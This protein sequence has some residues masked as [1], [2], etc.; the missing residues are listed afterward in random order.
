MRGKML[1]KQQHSSSPRRNFSIVLILFIMAAVLA[2]ATMASYMIITSRIIESSMYTMEELARHDKQAILASLNHRWSA[3]DGIAFDLRQ[4]KFETTKELQTRLSLD[5]HMT[6]CILLTL[7][8][9]NGD[10]ISSNMNISSNEALLKT[11]RKANDRFLYH[12][13]YTDTFIEGR[14]E[15]LVLGISMEP[16]SVEG[17]TFAYL[18]C[19]L[20]IDAIQDEL[21]IMSYD[22]RGYSS[23]IDMDGNYVVHM[24]N[25]YTA[26]G[27]ENF[28]EDLE[29]STLEKGYTVGQIR[30]RI[31]SRMTFSIRCVNPSGDSRIFSFSPLADTNWCF[32][33][34]V[35]RTVFEEQSMS[36]ISVVVWMLLLILAV[37]I[38]AV[39]I[40]L[41]RRSKTLDREI[42]YREE[43]SH[44]LTLAEQ[45]NRAKTIFLSNMSHDMRTPMN[46]II[47]FST[48]ATTHINN[49]SRVKNY[50]GKISQASAHLLSLINDVLDMSRIESGV[51]K[52]NTKVENLPEILRN[53]YNII[54]ADVQAKQLDLHI[55]AV[56]VINED[57]ICDRLRLNQ[58]LLNLMS[59]A[60]KYT[61]AGGS[62]FLRVVETKPPQP[63]FTCFEFR[64]KD[65][66]IGMS[67]EYLKIIFDPFTRE[68][69]STVSGIQG[70]GLGMSITKSI[71]ELMN[72]SIKV[73]STQGKGSEFVVSLTFK[74]QADT[75]AKIGVIDQLSGTRAL[76]VNDDIDSCQGLARML[77]LMGM[78]SEWVSNSNQALQRTH[79][80]AEIDD[81]YKVY[82]LDWQQPG[83]SSLEAV[84]QLR[85]AVGGDAHIIILSAQDWSDIEEQARA[86]GVTDFVSKPLFASELYRV[87]LNACETISGESAAQEPEEETDIFTGKR[88]L[89]AEDNELNREIAIEILS[90][91]GFEVET[92]ENGQ[93]A[94]DML[95][96]AQPGY[97]DLILMD[98]QMPVMNGHEA[99]RAIRALDNESLA[100]IPIIAMTAN[101]FEEDKRA[102]LAAGMDGHLGKPVDVPALMD[103]LSAMLL[104]SEEKEA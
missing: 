56:N 64:V 40:I 72:G 47:G 20:D 58:I 48:L 91:V 25:S 93:I 53:L 8:A 3:L 94:V 29:A 28:F 37:I 96:A 9:D 54:Q 5:R 31:R 59:N 80:A 76:V 90:E 32:I 15:V 6:E 12:E 43:L 24:G 45:A 82:I 97:Y 77:K 51:I 60:I 81:R 63:G 17:R 55:D 73:S 88:I 46:A 13:N 57:I 18:I 103:M 49:P 85:E 35:S 16:F 2:G 101:A 52:L 1:K 68:R 89:L 78:R 62:I 70:T 75:P 83:I 44:A 10:I 84:K 86:A 71:V 23:V 34:S 33:T 38:V 27:Q 26:Q 4:H 7:V 39:I 36:L 22:G 100:K 19:L 99:S 87:L 11:C 61:P 104:K 66:G 67:A 50:L 98:I 41:H 79:R 65:T 92:A 30:N 102:A 14:S 21:R 69:N 95:C 42:R 74:L